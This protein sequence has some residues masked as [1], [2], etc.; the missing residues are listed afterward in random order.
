M[1]FRFYSALLVLFSSATLCSAQ[2]V[3]GAITN[4][5][6]Y[7]GAIAPGSI[8]T[9]FG[10]D[11]TAEAPVNATITPL[12]FFLDQV[13]VYVNSIQAPLFYVSA[14]QINFQI[15][16]ETAVG[17]A[18]VY[19]QSATGST[20]APITI[21]IAA[22]GIFQ[23]G[24][25]RAIAVDYPSPLNAD[26][27]PAAAGSV[28]VVYM[29]GIGSVGSAYPSDGYPA[30]EDTLYPSIYT[31]T[32]SIGGA[33]A[34]VQFIGLAPGFV[35]LTQ[36]NIQV[37]SLPNG[38][39]PLTITLAVPSNDVTDGTGTSFTSQS[40]IVS[41]SGN[42]TPP[43]TI[44]TY[45]STASVPTSTLQTNVKGAA[46][47]QLNGT[48][49]YVCSV[50]QI[51]VI[52]V[53]NPTAPALAGSFGT[54]DLNGTGTLCTIDQDHLLELTNSSNL[55]VYDLSTSATSPQLVAGPT[56][57]QTPYSGNLAIDGNTVVFDT[58]SV[59]W[60][61]ATD[62]L[63]FEVGV[64]E[65]YDFTNFA[66]PT[67]LADFTPPSGYTDNTAERFGMANLGNHNIA[68]LGTTNNGV[69]NGGGSPSGEGQLT[70][71][72][73]ANPASPA[74][75]TELLVPQTVVLQSIALQ[76]T[77]ALIGGNTQ[78]INNPIVYV[79]N[80]VPEFFND[81]NLT[82]STVDFSNP[83]SPQILYTT[84]TGIQSSA[85]SYVVS[86]G[87]GFFAMTIAPPVVGWQGP[88]TL[89]VVDARN[90]AAPIL[91]PYAVIDGVSSLLASGSYLYVTTALGLNIYQITLP[92]S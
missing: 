14:D 65:A 60:S 67:F 3:I 68:V 21:A 61:L 17:S 54:T 36:A 43:P 58:S 84:V 59:N 88:S 18:T 66:S 80:G 22:P 47:V 23:Y 37:P 52:D 24:T 57:L 27:A 16:F 72:N 29:T 55:L 70:V 40:A 26:S 71:I 28:L 87:G 90:P 12:P 38:D 53:S 33:D 46:Y 5:S 73:V 77:T 9:L 75:V 10:T 64:I 81:G 50:D 7:S 4:A 6:D 69:N 2:P 13:T 91:Y 25:N 76:G 45:L 89:A 19:V 83:L 48:D 31:A 82:L 41:I 78:G 56:A 62:L 51:S 8:A 11:F 86:L 49:A 15:P 63:N 42:G 85:G 34:P 1:Q 30:P 35:G 92:A 74:G 39:Y 79:E 20:S 32:A 44:L